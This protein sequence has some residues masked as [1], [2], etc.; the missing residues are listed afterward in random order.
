MDTKLKNVSLRVSRFHLLTEPR[1][2]WQVCPSYPSS[3]E[4]SGAR[5]GLHHKE[6]GG[7]C[8]CGQLAPKRKHRL[9]SSM[10]RRFS[11]SPAPNFPVR[12]FSPLPLS[13]IQESW[14]RKGWRQGWYFLRRKNS[15]QGHCGDPATT[16]YHQYIE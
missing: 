15:L 9:E 11:P 7:I 2:E 1:D 8:F 16:L 12:E 6:Q 10:A 5:S 3:T 13:F 4:G 14:E